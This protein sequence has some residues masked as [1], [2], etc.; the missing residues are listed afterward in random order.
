MSFS[1]V[2][3]EGRCC[4]RE[5]F[6]RTRL[7]G[8]WLSWPNFAKARSGL[9][10]TFQKWEKKLAVPLGYITVQGCWMLPRSPGSHHQEMFCC[11]PVDMLAVTNIQTWVWERQD[12]RWCESRTWRFVDVNDLV[13]CDVYAEPLSLIVLKTDRP[14]TIPTARGQTR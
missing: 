3:R 4:D 1:G 2:V 10:L 6:P 14:V 7:S 5:N 9:V 11:N 8:S 12:G 13:S